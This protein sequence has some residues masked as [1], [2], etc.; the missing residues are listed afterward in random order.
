VLVAR[1]GH[2]VVSRGYGLA[3]VEHEVPNTPQTRFRIGSLTKQF[4]AMA[5]MMLQERGKLSVEDS[6]CKYLPDCP[7][8]FRSI[9]IHHLLT[10]TSGIPN[11]AYDLNRV[12]QIS[13]SSL[14]AH[15]MERLRG[16][17]LEFKAGERFSYSN[18]GYLLLGH[19]IER[20]S[21]EPYEQFL[22]ENIFEPLKMNDTGYEGRDSI[23]K[24]RASGYS[25]RKD[26]LRSAPFVDM[27]LPY[28]AG[29]LYSTVED[30]YLWDQALYT[31][32]LVS[33][34][35]LD[36][37]FTPFKGGYGY[38][39]DV[40]E[41]FGRRC[42]SHMGW[43]EG[44]ASY[45]LRVPDERLTVVVMSNV[46]GA[47]V[48]SMARDLAAIALGV[49][50]ATVREHKAVVADASLYDAYAGR[51]EL[52]PD[53]V[54]TITNEGG[55]LM[56]QAPGRPK[57]ELLPESEVEFFIKEYDA[58]VMFVWDGSGRVIR[59]VISLNGR[60]TEAGKIK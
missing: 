35:T 9:T 50:R 30:M 29:A 39:W 32:K 36:A 31:E 41:L 33:R 17:D 3:S 11:F 1:G 27:A 34:K 12:E 7:E 20:V 52:A 49:R 42:T 51:Y 56:A 25:L 4:T 59:A 44:Y 5:I 28:S 46:D 40:G 16:A 55:R 47:P 10:H 26:A 38:G 14:L 37:I 8:K 22:R 57:L 58:Q 45:I 13:Q 6:I 48:S 54:V 43:I 24:H 19:V 15:H 2:V 21:G 53:F 60:E 23:V 18:T